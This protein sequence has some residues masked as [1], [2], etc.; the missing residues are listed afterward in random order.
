MKTPQI[1]AVCFLLTGLLVESSPSGRKKKPPAKK[2]YDSDSSSG[3]SGSVKCLWVGQSWK[4]C[5]I[6][7]SNPKDV[8]CTFNTAEASKYRDRSP[9]FSDDE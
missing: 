8:K 3:S 6:E 7:P 1:A 4:E 9:P 5:Q 2:D